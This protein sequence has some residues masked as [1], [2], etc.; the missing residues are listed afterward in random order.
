MDVLKLCLLAGFPATRESMCVT[1]PLALSRR[2]ASMLAHQKLRRLQ[3]LFSYCPASAEHGQ[4]GSLNHATARYAEH[5]TLRMPLDPPVS[6]A[7]SAPAPFAAATRSSSSGQLHSNSLLQLAWL[8]SISAPSC[9]S[10]CW[11]CHHGHSYFLNDMMGLPFQLWLHGPLRLLGQPSAPPVHED[12]LLGAH[13]CCTLQ[14]SAL[15]A[16]FH[17]SSRRLGPSHTNV[18]NTHKCQLV[19]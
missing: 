16:V 5:G 18:Q 2:M 14:A 1:S 4:P 17:H 11:A 10:R 7:P 13:V 3:R 15:P 19:L 12:Y 8:A 6:R 9:C